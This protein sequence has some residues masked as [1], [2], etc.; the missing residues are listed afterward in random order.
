MLVSFEY[1]NLKN[2]AQFFSQ[3]QNKR[4]LS[5]IGVFRLT[6]AFE[7]FEI[8]RNLVAIFAFYMKLLKS[9]FL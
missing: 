8:S 9:P 4:I 5:F 7:T 3:R 6:R 1:V 2:F